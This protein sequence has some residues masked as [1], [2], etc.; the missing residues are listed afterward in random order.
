[1]TQAIAA[2]LARAGFADATRVPLA[3]DG[4]SRR[5]E[6]LIRPDGGT[7]I[8]VVTPTPKTDIESFAE[9][10]GIL[11][12]HGFSVPRMLATEIDDG[13][14]VQEDFGDETFAQRLAA[15]GDPAEVY[16]LAT[17]ALIE[18]HRRVPDS[19]PE[20]AGRPVF[21]AA[22]FLEQTMLFADV[23]V[24]LALGRD[25]TGAERVDFAEAWRAVIEPACRG[26]WSLILRDYFPDN[27]MV[28]PREGIR[29]AGL[30]DFQDG[31]PGPVAY[32]LVSL[33]EDARRDV[34]PDLTAAMIDRYL[35]AFPG[36]DAAAFRRSYAVLGALRH[37][38]VIGIFERLALK[39]GRRGYLAHLPRVWRL[40]DAKLTDPALAPVARWFDRC[41]PESARGGFVVPEAD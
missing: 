30:I 6:R 28:L 1:M 18:L 2:I 14:A 25:L 33:L 39:A 38:R 29:A 34:A 32:D 40:L 9:I 31:R 17:D 11:A 24:P 37:A 19:A 5:Y 22:T 26:P 15:G 7:A 13:L 8:L 41:M 3:G 20:L 4:S 36:L 21:D 10:G 35:K 23:H 12:A 27:L 16:A